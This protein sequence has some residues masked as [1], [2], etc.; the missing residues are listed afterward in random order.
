MKRL[1]A[2]LAILSIIILFGDCNKEKSL[3]LKFEGS[4]Y[5]TMGHPV[6]N[7]EITLFNSWDQQVY[8]RAFTDNNGNYSLTHKGCTFEGWTVLQARD[9]G[10]FRSRVEVDY[11]TKNLQIVNFTLE[12]IFNC[13]T[14]LEDERDGKEYATIKI[15]ELCWMVSNLNIGLR[16]DGADNQ[17]DNNVIEKYCYGDDEANCD[18][19]GGLYQWDE[20]MQYDQ[21]YVEKDFRGIC[22]KG[23]H[24][25]R[26]GMSEW[27]D[28]FKYL[29]GENVAGGKMKEVGTSHWNPPNTGASNES[30]FT[31]LPGGWRYNTDGSFD[32]KGTNANFWGTSSGGSL[33]SMHLLTYDS[34]TA[35]YYNYQKTHGLSVRCIAYTTDPW[36]VLVPPKK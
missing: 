17:T 4:V 31:A 2:F 5:D 9:S 21:F 29:G 11:C 30:G 32:G 3:K 18:V 12:P 25:P 15:G 7:A 27:S 20:M 1:S 19:Y 36:W 16:I 14:I 33:S 13:G 22:P 34:D 28:L 8:E 24:V 23:W 26:S 6:F 35:Y 10:F